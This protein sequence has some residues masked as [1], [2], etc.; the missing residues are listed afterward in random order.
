MQYARV[1]SEIVYKTN[2]L[3][4]TSPV[5]QRN[6]IDPHDVLM[7]N[8]GKSMYHNFMDCN[9]LCLRKWSPSGQMQCD[10]LKWNASEWGSETLRVTLKRGN[11]PE[12]FILMDEL[13]EREMKKRQWYTIPSMHPTHC[14]VKRGEC[15]HLPRERIRVREWCC[16][17]PLHWT[18]S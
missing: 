8:D 7:H 6:N 18:T 17:K 3:V 11:L 15:T 10:G 4:T 14:V 1:H 9:G 2:S 5:P 16:G 12:P 13:E